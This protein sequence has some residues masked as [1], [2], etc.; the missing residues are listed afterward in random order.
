MEYIIKTDE[1]GK[2][3]TVRMVQEKLYEAMKD[4]DKICK[5]NKIDY[6][7]TDG[8]CLGAVRHK[9]FIPWDDDVD[10]G[11]SRDDYNRFIKVLDKELPDKYV[12]HCYEKNKKYIVA[13]PAMKIRIKDTYVKEKNNIFLPNRCK[14]SDGIFIDVVIY[15]HMSKHKII[16]LPLRLI[17]TILM[18][19]MVLF[20]MIHI[21]PIILKSLFRFNARIY[22]KLCKNS[23]YI[24]D[25]LTWV[26]NNPFKPYI[27]KYSDIYPTK[28]IKF[29]NSKFSVPGNYN[30]YLI[31]K[32]GKNY[33]TPVK[34]SKRVSKHIKDIDLNSS[35][36]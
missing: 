4:I 8:T 27:M 1:D 18:P 25:E 29:E 17:N 30:N 32:F 21:N 24:G 28:R 19:I 3:I 14:D 11:M 10:I 33:M 6:F 35:R 26:Y 13:Y 23:E 16:D 9:G 22:G 20:D 12:Y 2:Q 31:A 5:K 34:E 7:L 36:K 15:D